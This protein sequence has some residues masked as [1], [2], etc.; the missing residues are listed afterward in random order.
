MSNQGNATRDRVNLVYRDHETKQE[1]ELPFKIL[2]IGDYSGHEDDRP[3]DERKPIRVDRSNVTAV[4]AE[5]DLR[6]RFNAPNALSEDPED[7]MAIDLRLRSFADFGPEW[8][9]QQVP[10][11]RTLIES[12]R[13]LSDL[14][15]WLGG[16]PSL[17]F[18]LQQALASP[19]N[20]AQLRRELGIGYGKQSRE[21]DR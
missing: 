19:E 9:A 2:V 17:V 13:S 21:G 15:D 1:K 20:R 8:V 11:L 5:M 16:S 12:R 6:L 10:E 14:K 4:M 7:T 3:L 18:R